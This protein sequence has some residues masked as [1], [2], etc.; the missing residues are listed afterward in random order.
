M[1][2]NRFNQLILSQ[3]IDQLIPKIRSPNAYAVYVKFNTR[4]CV[5]NLLFFVVTTCIC[6]CSYFENTIKNIVLHCICSNV[7]CS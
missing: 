5:F 2:L 1:F 6:T 4:I 3:L 7:S